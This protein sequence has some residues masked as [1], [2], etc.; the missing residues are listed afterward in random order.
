MADIRSYM[1]EKEKREQKQRE[2]KQREKRQESYKEKIRKHKLAAVYR[3]ML[4]LAA[5]IALTALVIVQYKRHLYTGYDVI[6]SVE[7]TDVSGARD[8]RLGSSVLTY[9]RDGV[10][11]MDSK[12]VVNWNQTYDIQDVRLSVCGSTVAVGEYNGRSIYVANSE[13]LLGE[14][15]TTMPIRNLAVSADGKVTAVLADTDVTWLNTYDSNGKLLYYG[16]TR[17]NNSGYPAA[18]A[19]SPNGELLCVAY[20]YVDAGVMKTDVAFYNFGSV[21]ENYSDHFVSV[22]TY[23]DMLVPYVQFMN[24]KTAFAVGDNRLMIYSGGHVPE[25]KREDLYDEE[26]KSVYYNEKYIGLVFASD[27]SEHLY[28]LAVYDSAA[29]AENVKVG[30]FYFDIEY[31]D[32]F[33]GQDNFV[34]YNESKCLIKTMDGIE[35]YNGSFSK[36]V[37]LMLPV[38]NTYKYLLVTD[39]SIDTIQLK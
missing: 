22:Y 8:L 30:V 2:Q 16:Q 28:K 32:I 1:K 13:K 6:A 38:G 37:R 17:M 21:G 36:A 20:I 5:V 12:G 15:T 25:T 34:I 39:S 10:H 4:V 9:S 29:E 19:L 33:F 26:V 23:R 11:C 24:D 27:D 7:R 18:I 35:K 14:I 31:T 3:I